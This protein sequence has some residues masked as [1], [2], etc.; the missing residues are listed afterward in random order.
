[1]LDSPEVTCEVIG[2]GHHV[3]PAVMRLIH[4][5]KGTAGTVLVTDA[6]EA[7]GLPDGD[8]HLAAVPIRVA[9]GRAVTAEGNL[10]GSTLTMDG[11]VRHAH[12]WL[13]VPLAEALAMASTTPARVIGAGHKGRIAPGCDADLVVLDEQLHPVATYVAGRSGAADEP[14]QELA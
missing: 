3:H 13:R 11:A 1:V 10:A 4:R 7:T 5:A 14:A 6:I 2:D 12:E 9:S 8:Y